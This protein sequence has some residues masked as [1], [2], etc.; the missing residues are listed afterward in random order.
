MKDLTVSAFPAVIALFLPDCKNLQSEY[1]ASGEEITK[2]SDEGTYLSIAAPFGCNH[3]HVNINAIESASAYDYSLKDLY[4]LEAFPELNEKMVITIS[5][6][7]LSPLVAVP[8]SIV[9][10]E[11]L[12]DNRSSEMLLDIVQNT[13]LSNY[14]AVAPKIQT[15]A[16]NMVTLRS[17]NKGYKESGVNESVSKGKHAHVPDVI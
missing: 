4:S 10:K 5:A 17:S 11:D 13:P 2:T 1:S 16:P 15:E 8:F 14:Q 7:L 12:S 9:R 6:S 3:H